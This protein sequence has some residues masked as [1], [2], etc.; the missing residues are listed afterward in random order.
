MCEPPIP[1]HDHSGPAEGGETLRPSDLATSEYP[2]VDVRSFG[3]VGD[4]RTDDGEAFQAAVDA[5]TPRGTVRIPAGV[6]LYFSEPIDVD[7]GVGDE[8][9]LDPGG[10]GPLGGDATEQTP[11]LLRCEG[12]LRPAP[13]LRPA[14]HVHNGIL[15][16]V[17]VRIQGATGSGGGTALRISDLVGG[18]FECTATEYDG[19][20]VTVDNGDTRTVDITVERLYA[21]NC[22]R[23][24]TMQ[25]G[26]TG[27]ALGRG[28]GIG[29]VFEI[30]EHDVDRSGTFHRIT[31]LSINAYHSDATDHREAGI[32]FEEC[33]GIA[34]DTFAVDGP[35][36][37][38]PSRHEDSGG[39]VDN[40]T[41]RDVRDVTVGSLATAGASGSGFVLDSAEGVDVDRVRAVDNG[42]GIEYDETGDAPT[43]HTRLAVEAR[44]NRGPGLVIRD[45]VTGS[46][47]LISGTIAD[48]GAE[49]RID[50]VAADR[51]LLDG[52][53]IREAATDLR[54][55]GDR[56]S[57]P[58]TD[59]GNPDGTDDRS[60]R[61]PPSETAGVRITN[62]RIE[63][64]EG[65]P[66]TVNYVG[67]SRWAD[68]RP[69]RDAWSVGDIVF[70][71]TAE[72]EEPTVYLQRRD[73][74]WAR[75]D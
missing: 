23:S 42:I 24:I 52:L 48:N 40:V 32:V 68:G 25:P 70:Q 4:G 74:R 57:A 75:L 21:S 43:A 56:T 8:A 2:E 35:G 54:I 10:D 64:I 51:I 47:H 34:V 1:E 69:D 26:P 6:D 9:I 61:H 31:G 27:T 45:R 66:R 59:R 33:S 15:P 36:A 5:A 46:D 12:L 58:P 14:I 60:D 71:A 55:A 19:T 13:E 20:V 37:P 28:R 67:V 29:H 73:G 53:S 41:F 17:A 38:R 3:V 62:S 7:L 65:D 39:T 72:Q 18:R 30:L 49:T 16:R 22:G 63:A 11:F 44:N 50:T